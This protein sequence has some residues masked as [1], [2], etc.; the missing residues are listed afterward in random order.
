MSPINLRDLLDFKKSNKPI[1]INEVESDRKF[2]K[3]VW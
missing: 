2:N 3:E 1:N